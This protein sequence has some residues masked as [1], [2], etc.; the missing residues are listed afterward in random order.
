[1]YNFYTLDGPEFLF[2]DLVDGIMFQ[3]HT[4]DLTEINFFIFF[5]FQ[6]DFQIFALKSVRLLCAQSTWNRLTLFKILSL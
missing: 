2:T 1:M 5:R 3:K 6:W 4:L